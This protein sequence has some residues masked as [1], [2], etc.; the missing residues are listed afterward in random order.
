MNRRALAVCMLCRRRLLLHR[1]CLPRLCICRCSVHAFVSVSHLYSLYFRRCFAFTCHLSPHRTL[2]VPAV[3]LCCDLPLAR[4]RR[5][6]LFSAYSLSVGRGIIDA[7]YI[8][9]LSICPYIPYI[10]PYALWFRR[11]PQCNSFTRPISLTTPI[12]TRHA[13]TAM[14][15]NAIQGATQG[16]PLSTSRISALIVGTPLSKKGRR[17][18]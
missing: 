8:Y 17:R 14:N 10:H 6:I 9:M 3:V 1:S 5:L 7:M 12:W 18:G 15:R 4:S 16:R 13:L 2:A 11:H